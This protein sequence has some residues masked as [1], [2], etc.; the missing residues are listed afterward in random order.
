MTAPV[1]PKRRMLQFDGHNYFRQRLILA[2]LSRKSIRIENIRSEDEEYP[3]LADY[4]AS[5]LRLLEKITNGS[6]IEINYAG[7]GVTYH[8]GTISGG[9]ITHECPPSRAIGYFLESIIALAP[10][11]KDSLE[12]TL[13]GITNDNVDTSVD[14]IR[15]LLLPQLN[16]FGIED[17]V[18]LKISKRG[19]APLGG[20]QVTFT[21]PIVRQL[22]PVQF[23]D[24]GHIKRIR[25]IAY[26]TRMSP[27]MANRVVEAARGILTR[28]IPDVYIYTDV[29][30]GQESGKSPGY[31]LSLV[32]E[33]TTQAL[34][35]TNVSNMLVNDYS[36]PTPEDLGVR[37][38]R[39]LLHEIKRGGTVD[40]LSQWLN[41]LFIAL[42]PEDVG[43]VRFGGL[44]PF[45][46]QYLRDLKTFFDVTF[47]IVADPTSHTVLLTSVGIGF[48]NV[49]KKVT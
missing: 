1:P 44:S 16:R 27:Q 15:T 17:G 32:A 8:P 49:N 41:L 14:L 4:E 36:F 39:L 23:I 28:Y 38:A 31:A 24:P 9:R 25:G 42:G 3:G 47:K 22:K 48:T 12:L 26:A 19:A 6:I 46:I 30:K 18:E 7:T 10:F 29:Y 37:A 20:G 34:H 35:T 11:A 21:C 2:T 5:F 43:K 45:T 33:S 40:T 13:I